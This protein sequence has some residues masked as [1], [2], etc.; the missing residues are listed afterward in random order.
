MKT[1]WGRCPRR[2]RSAGSHTG[3]P[4]ASQH[5]LFADDGDA[6]PGGDRAAVKYQA[7]GILLKPFTAATL[8]EKLAN[9]PKLQAA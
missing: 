4:G 7:D 8:K 2:R 5:L 9:I 1:G 6:R 3:A